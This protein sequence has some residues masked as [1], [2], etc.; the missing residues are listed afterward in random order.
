MYVTC[1]LFLYRIVS[2]STIFNTLWK[3]ISSRIYLYL[4]FAH[5]QLYF[6]SKKSI[7]IWTR[8]CCTQACTTQCCK[9]ISNLCI[10]I[11]VLISTSMHDA[12]HVT[13]VGILT[14]KIWPIPFILFQFMSYKMHAQCIL[15]THAQ[16][17][18]GC[19][20]QLT[21]TSLETIER[22][23]HYIKGTLNVGLTFQK[24]PSIL[25]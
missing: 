6:I 2:P 19:D 14:P 25:H 17:Y 5:I 10:F 7:Y 9:L 13:T 22:V 23:L 21:F 8:A 4:F 1:R 24:S 3:H 16:G 15:Y 11:Y 18:V 12:M 20:L